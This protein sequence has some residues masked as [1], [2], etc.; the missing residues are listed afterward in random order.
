[1]PYNRD[2]ADQRRKYGES[3]LRRGDEHL[4][5]QRAFEAEAQARLDAA[6]QRRQEEKLRL[7]E[8]EVRAS[9]LCFVVVP[10]P[11]VEAIFP[12]SVPKWR[13]CGYK[14]S[15]LPNSDVSHESR[16]WSGPEKFRWRATKSVNAN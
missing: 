4:A 3:M 6:R 7:E 10:A 9:S 8:V 2:L 14:P 13:N 1:M 15:N 5:S 16:L 12:N 11:N